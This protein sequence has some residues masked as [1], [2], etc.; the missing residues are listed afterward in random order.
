MKKAGD[1]LFAMVVEGGFRIAGQD[2]LRRDAIGI[3]ETESV[4]I[5][6]IAEKSQLLLIEVPMYIERY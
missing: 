4:Q 3:W 5:E 6:S 1:G 2:L